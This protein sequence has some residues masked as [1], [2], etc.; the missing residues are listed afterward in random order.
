MSLRAQCPGLAFD[1]KS[2]ARTG[3]MGGTFVCIELNFNRATLCTMQGSSVRLIST[4]SFRWTRVCCSDCSVAIKKLATT[5]SFGH[6]SQ[7]FFRTASIPAWS[8]GA[9]AVGTCYR[10]S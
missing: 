1:C 2:S 6:R 7:L 5:A 9:A 3:W 8:F 10:G 4:V